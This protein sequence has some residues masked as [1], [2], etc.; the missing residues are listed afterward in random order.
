MRVIYY[1]S[2]SALLF[3]SYAT[4]TQAHIDSSLSTGLIEY[5]TKTKPTVKPK[6]QDF[7]HFT[8]FPSLRAEQSLRSEQ[9]ASAVALH[10]G[11]AN[12]PIKLAAVNFI[13]QT[14]SARGFKNKDASAS[15][16]GYPYTTEMAVANC[17]SVSICRD[18]YLQKIKCTSCK[19][20]MTLG[21]DGRCKCNQKVYSYNVQNNPCMYGYDES[22][23]CQEVG[24]DGFL[25]V[26]YAA[27]SCPANWKECNNV[28]EVG[29]GAACASNGKNYYSNCTCQSPYTYLCTGTGQNYDEAPSGSYCTNTVTGLRYYKTCTEVCW[30]GY[31]HSLQDWWSTCV[32][33]SNSYVP[34]S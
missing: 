31:Y 32:C 9:A 3:S 22:N 23:V 24:S 30:R 7:N 25:K 27:C 8:S 18:G 21:S 34:G 1:L 16:T 2:C 28:G 10:L 17:A 13:T 11:S 20:S 6:S 19:N 4:T 26:Y 29:F 5:N 15:C 12:N 33:S 14:D